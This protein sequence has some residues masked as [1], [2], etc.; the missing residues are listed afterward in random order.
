MIGPLIPIHNKRRRLT[1][2]VLQITGQLELLLNR[3]QTDYV[4]M[5]MLDEKADKLTRLLKTL[6]A[7]HDEHNRPLQ[8]YFQETGFAELFPCAMARLSLES[9]ASGKKAHNTGIHGHFQSLTTLNQ[10]VN[11][12]IQLQHDIGLDCH[13]FVPHQLTVLYQ[14]L[15]PAGA[16]YKRYKGKIEEEFDRIKAYLAGEVASTRRGGKNTLAEDDILDAPLH[17]NKFDSDPMAVDAPPPPGAALGERQRLS[18][19]HQKWLRDL[20]SEI[21]LE[22]LMIYSKDVNAMVEALVAKLKRRQ[23]TGSFPIALETA[24]LLRQIVS[25]SRWSNAAELIAKIKLEGRRLASAQ[26]KDVVVANIVRRI[27]HLIRVAYAEHVKDPSGAGLTGTAAVAAAYEPRSSHPHLS[28]QS[29]MFTLLGD[30]ADSPADLKVAIPHL[31]SEI[32]QEIQEFIEELEDMYTNIATQAMDHI[33]SNEVI[34]TAGCSKTVELFLKFAAK[35]RQFKVIVVESAPSYRGHE[36]ALALSGAGIDTTLIPDSAVFAMMARVNKVILG[37]S[38]ILANGGLISLSGSQ[39]IVEAAKH[40]SIPV[41]VCG[42]IFKLSPVF[43]FDEDS[44]NTL[45]SPDSVLSFDNG[46]AVA[47]V[48]IVNPQYDYVAPEFID[49]FITNL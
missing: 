4:Q 41:I 20:T 43:P 5:M 38:A 17:P 42:G 26:P 11:I 21:V 29:S 10:V 28:A 33:H 9:V 27:L 48:E 16:E 22:A 6:V 47:K 14:C 7:E 8:A 2:R 23:I 24:A 12:C 18:G 39:M 45:V 35:K 3:E 1:Q 15:G 46:D 40:H 49:L 44:L 25:V 34:M 13:R 36:M 30:P 19:Y 37:T 31:K 32:I